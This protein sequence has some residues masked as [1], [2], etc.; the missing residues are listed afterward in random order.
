MAEVFDLYN[1]IVLD[2]FGIANTAAF[3]FASLFILS[4]LAA[5]FRMPNKVFFSIILVYGI[6]ISAFFQSILIIVIFLASNIIA[7]GI[8]KLGGNR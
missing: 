1:L 5:K 3:I 8:G 7:I 2:I 4:Y 6:I